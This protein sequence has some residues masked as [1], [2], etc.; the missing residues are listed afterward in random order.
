MDMNQRLSIPI[1]TT[2]ADIIA[3]FKAEADRRNIPYTRAF[4]EAARMWVGC[5]APDPAG[6]ATLRAVESALDRVADLVKEH[7]DAATDVLRTRR[8]PPVYTDA[9]A[10]TPDPFAAPDPEPAPEAAPADPEPYRAP[11]PEEN[12]FK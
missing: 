3:A 1:N 12:P 4:T 5:D 6:D 2:N 11:M 7:L 10:C 9:Q 8:V